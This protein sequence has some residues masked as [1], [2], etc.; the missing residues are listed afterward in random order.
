MKQ[1]LAP[2]FFCLCVHTVSAQC[3]ADAGNDTLIC[4]QLWTGDTFLGGS[5]TAIGGTEPYTYLWTCDY[6]IGPIEYTASDLLDDISSPNPQLMELLGGDMLFGLTVTDADGN[7]CTD[8][9]TIHVCS[10]VNTEEVKQAWIATGDTTG[11]YTAATSPCV[12]LTYQ[13]SPDYNISDTHAISPE[14]WPEI[15]TMYTVTVTD[16]SECS[17]EDVFFVYV[18]PLEI[19][20]TEANT[21]QC[22]PNPAKGIT[23]LSIPCPITPNMQL[24][25]FDISGRMILQENI[26]KDQTEINLRRYTPGM[27]LYAL[28]DGPL[29]LKR[30]HIIIF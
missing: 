18:Y 13:W 1:L 9:V 19:T 8:S 30:D 6:N 4:D 25:I 27:Y 12:P 29:I 3:I 21:I 16:Q 23:T 11:I 5:P 15:T 22:Y 14:V 10:F 20:E 2:L 26:T 28:S 7:V 17:L 24:Q